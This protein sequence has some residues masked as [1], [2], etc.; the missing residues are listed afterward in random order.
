MSG[1]RFSWRPTARREKRDTMVRL[2]NRSKGEPM[3]DT[4]K[5]AGFAAGVACA[6]GG[7]LLWGFSGVCIQW[8]YA[9]YEVQ[10]SFITA[11]RALAAGLVFCAV[12]LVTRRPLL[13]EMLSSP[14]TVGRLCVF[15]FGLFGSQFFY[16]MSVSFTNAGTATVLQMSGTVFIM[17]ATCLMTRTL[18]G[19]RQVLGLACALAGTYLIATQGNA[20]VLTLPAAGLAWG[21]VNGLAV[22][23]YIMY[24]KRLFAEFGSFAATG[25]A[26]LVSGVLSAGVYVVQTCVIASSSID[27]S[28]LDAAGYAVLLVCVALLGTFAA[29]GLYLRGVSIVGSVTGSLLG[30]C[31]PLGAMVISALWMGTAFTGWDWAGF[32]L[33]LA[34]LALVTV[35]SRADRAA[36]KN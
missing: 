21:M 16:A 34:M 14:R 30:A 32:A 35:P 2:T 17:V 27:F 24:P 22:A 12:L 26:M 15:G 19:I 6:V 5:R 33:M 4:S 10:G 20:G 23:L 36:E 13:K 29:F 28:A 8:L 31:E 1:P 25:L 3:P 18:P 9:N 7:A 11:V